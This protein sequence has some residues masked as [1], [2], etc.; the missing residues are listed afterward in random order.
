MTEG[1]TVHSELNGS[2]HFLKLIYSCCFRKCIFEL[3]LSVQ[4]TENFSTCSEE[5]VGVFMVVSLWILSR[6]EHRDHW[7]A[8]L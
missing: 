7:F 8:R 2:R 5:L 3:W 1:K 4:N 6:Y